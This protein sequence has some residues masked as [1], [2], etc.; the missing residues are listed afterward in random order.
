[1]P[2]TFD[3]GHTSP[4]RKLIVDKMI[5]A[6]SPLLVPTLPGGSAI[7]FLEA[8]IPI[9]YRVDRTDDDYAIDVLLRDLAG[10]SPAVAIAPLDLV[11]KQ[12]GGPGRAIAELEIEVY[13]VSSHERDLTEGRAA[14]DAIAAADIT[15]DPGIWAVL[16]LVWMYLFDI[17]MGIATVHELKLER[18]AEIICNETLTIW[19]MEWSIQV[20]RDANLYRGLS[21]LFTNAKTT[22]DPTDDQ[23]DT[24]NI[25]VDTTVG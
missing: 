15:A 13:V 12:A 4:Q 11:S 10:R 19:K 21:Q 14:S 8:I 7:G 5:A 1:M 17:K 6:L 23:P 2:H 25:K 24:Q 22:L 16:E 9:S 20:G 18:E 3:T